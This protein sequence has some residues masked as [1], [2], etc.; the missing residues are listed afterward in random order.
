MDPAVSGVPDPDL[1]PI[2]RVL[3]PE[4][5]AAFVC[6]LGVAETNIVR[7]DKKSAIVDMI[8][9]RR[10]PGELVDE[11]KRRFW[12]SPWPCRSYSRRGPRPIGAKNTLQGSAGSGTWSARVRNMSDVMPRR[13]KI[14]TRPGRAGGP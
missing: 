11:V 10:P 2:R 8:R 9:C 5:A 14:N 12:G 3:H 6:F 1:S 4:P 13:R 7:P